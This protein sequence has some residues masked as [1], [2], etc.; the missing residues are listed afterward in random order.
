MTDQE[1]QY[2]HWKP[3]RVLARRITEEMVV[4][5]LE[6]RV[7]GSVG[8]WLIQ[9]IR[10]ELYPCKDDIFRATYELVD[11][12]DGT[13]E[14]VCEWFE[15]DDGLMQTG[16]GDEFSFECEVAVWKPGWDYCPHCGKRIV[17]KE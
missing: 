10:G 15:D 17:V 3:I 11:T 9:G 5:T 16:C 2:Y 8:D 14:Q 1:Y 7:V 13:N 6:G 4:P 12:N